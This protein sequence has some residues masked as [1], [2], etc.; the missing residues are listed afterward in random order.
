MSKAI[1]EVKLDSVLLRNISKEQAKIKNLQDFIHDDNEI[2]QLIYQKFPL[3]SYGRLNEY[4]RIYGSL[5]LIE[6][7]QKVNDDKYDLPNTKLNNIRFEGFN[8]KNQIILRFLKD[9]VSLQ[10]IVAEGEYTFTNDFLNLFFQLGYFS[11]FCFKNNYYDLLSECIQYLMEERRN[12]KSQYRLILKEGNYFIRGITSTKYKNYDN[13]LALYLTLLSLHAYAKNEN[14]FF[15]I[16]KANLTDSDIEIFIEQ[17]SPTKISNIGNVYFGMYISN[18]E[19]GKKAFS[20]ELNYKFIDNEGKC[21]RAFA[22]NKVF[23][24]NHSTSIQNVETQLKKINQ[25]E[26]MKGETLEQIHYMLNNPEVDDNTLYEMVYKEIDRKTK[27]FSSETRKKARELYE[28]SHINNTINIIKIFQRINQITDIEEEKLSLER[29]YH[30][31]LIRMN[32]RKHR[33]K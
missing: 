3:T 9:E 30:D 17:D 21:F 31:V 12:E 4:L 2:E 20:V 13:H 7:F 29:I 26:K 5:S 24:I 33:K 8:N 14:I 11:K 16:I 6:G 28:E 23:K 27:T 19:I 15:K 1:K 32:K 18:N 22:K 10:D 25:L